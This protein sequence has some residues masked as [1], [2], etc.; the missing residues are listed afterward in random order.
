MLKTIKKYLFLFVIVLAHCNTTGHLIKSADKQDNKI[1]QERSNREYKNTQDYIDIINSSNLSD[2][3]KKV[4]IKGYEDKDALIK[5][6]DDK[7]KEYSTRTEAH[8]VDSTQR[9]KEAEKKEKTCIQEQKDCLIDAGYGQSFKMIFY[10]LIGLSVLF[11]IYYAMKTG[12][13]G[14]IKGSK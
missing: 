7:L 12:L 14:I 9:I 4:L 3:E 1:E 5:F 11:V 13:W 8:R 2:L 6:K 10:G